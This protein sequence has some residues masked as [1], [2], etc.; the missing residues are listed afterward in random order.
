[1]GKRVCGQETRLHWF[2]PSDASVEVRRA[3][4][5]PTRLAL[6]G[7]P[8][9]GKGTQAELICRRYRA[10]HLATGDLFRAASGD[11]HPS[12]AMA[13]ALDAVRQGGLV[14]DE[15]VTRLV[16]ERA[17]CLACGGGFLLDGVPRTVSQ[18]EALTELLEELG[19][20][21]DGVVLYELDEASI[22]ERLGG[23]RTCGSCGAVFHVIARP[24]E[25]PD[26]CD[27][28]GAELVQRE[29]DKPHVIRKRFEAYREATEP[30]RAYYDARG[31]LLPLAA[32]GAPEA[33]F[34][35]TCEAID[36]SR[37]ERR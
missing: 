7:P 4:T 26:V 8:G 32:D 22:T 15:L 1:M 31:E 13:D 17:G 25:Q 20:R 21:L 30:V 6:L 24:P 16:R 11:D 5:P 23:R 28:C 14:S 2:H 35:R 33:V 9:A 19:I 29:D 36:R 27:R 10:C 12:P 3:D 37:A 18:A 34:E